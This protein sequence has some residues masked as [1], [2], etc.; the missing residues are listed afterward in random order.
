VVL[1][2]EYNEIYTFNY[3]LSVSCVSGQ[4]KKQPPK[5]ELTDSLT[6]SSGTLTMN[7]TVGTPV[8][9]TWNGWL[10]VG[11]TMTSL[12]SK[13]LPITEPPTK[14]QVTQTLA[15]SGVVGVL[16]TFTTTKNGITC[17]NWAAINTG[18]AKSK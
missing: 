7:F 5:C 4:C 3:N 1:V 18:S 11:N 10:T 9:V 6:Y 13:Q 14:E 15:P 12:F 2:Y 8:V 17:S 16:S